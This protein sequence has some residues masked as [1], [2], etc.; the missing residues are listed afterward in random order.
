MEFNGNKQ[1]GYNRTKSY[2]FNFIILYCDD[3]KIDNL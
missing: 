1:E 2:F 3:S